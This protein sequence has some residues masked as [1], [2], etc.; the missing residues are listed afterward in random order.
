MEPEIDDF[1]S[2]GMSRY[3]QASATLVAFRQEVESRLQRILTARA[4]DRWGR[5]VP[6]R[7]KPI[8]ST[9]TWSQYPAVLAQINGAID[10]ATVSITIDISWWNAEG[11]YPF[12][13]AVFDTAEP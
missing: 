4:P 5:F 11:E 9:R 7:V 3:K 6:D 8:K 12:Y 1:L 2:V 13:E 10:G